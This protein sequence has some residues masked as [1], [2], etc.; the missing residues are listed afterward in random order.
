MGVEIFIAVLLAIL[1]AKVIW[2]ITPFLLTI[3]I[4]LYIVGSG[5]L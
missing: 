4:V 3:L 1:A 2:E 5:G